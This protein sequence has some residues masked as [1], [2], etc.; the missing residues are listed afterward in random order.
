M[1]TTTIAGAQHNADVLTTAVS[2]TLSNPTSYLDTL[3][4]IAPAAEY[5]AANSILASLAY[6]VINQQLFK[7]RKDHAQTKSTAPTVDWNNDEYAAKFERRA[8][9]TMSEDN[10]HTTLPEFDA[11]EMTGVYIG[12]FYMQRGNL[13]YASKYPPKLPNEILHEMQTQDRSIEIREAQRAL[14]DARIAASPA[15]AAILAARNKGDVALTE[16]QVK[17]HTAEMAAVMAALKG[18]VPERLT[19]DRWI[20]IPLYIQYKFSFFVYNQV[21]RAAA[22]EANAFKRDDD[23]FEQLMELADTIYLELDAASRTAEVRYAFS[24]GR[25][26]ER[27]D[28][29][30]VET[31]HED[32]P[33]QHV[34]KAR[35]IRT[36]PPVDEPA[37]SQPAI[38]DNDR[39]LAAALT[40]ASAER[41]TLHLKH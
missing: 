35:E 41:K 16:Y 34:V 1:K 25:L 10:G 15:R 39:M 30:V 13:T 20:S 26:D 33:I 17:Q 21:I 40:A 7:Y 18:V 11:I 27:F 23:K 9:A 31:M 24:S 19:D 2:D 36:I 22:Q 4:N 14:D 32:A 3:A 8:D 5:F 28:L 38:T 29:H 12:L 6:S 37:S